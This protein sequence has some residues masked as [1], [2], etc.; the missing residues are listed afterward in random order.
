[1]KV[2]NL[3]DI[4]AEEFKSDTF[5]GTVFRQFPLGEGVAKE[6][7]FM[8]VNFG[9]GIRNHWHLHSTEQ[10]LYVTEGKG[11]V[12]TEKEQVVVGPGAVIFIPPGEKHWHGATKES[13]FTHISIQTPG[14]ITFLETSKA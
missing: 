4:K 5:T 10:I 3:S 8:V 2:A 13:S 1:M 11:I 12:A 9:P 7:Q 6:L 14:K